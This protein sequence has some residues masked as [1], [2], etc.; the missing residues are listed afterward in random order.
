MRGGT[1]S[2]EV[3]KSACPPGATGDLFREC[4]ANG[5]GGVPFLVDGPQTT[6]A[7][8]AGPIGSVFFGQLPAGRYTIAEMVPSGDYAQYV[9]Y[10]SD[11]AGVEVPFEYRGNGRAAVQ[12]EVADGQHVVC[13]WYN[14]PAPHAIPTAAPDTEIE[15][16]GV[17]LTRTAWG[18]L[19]GSG[20]RSGQVITY[21]DGRYDVAFAQRFVI[22]IE[23]GWEEDGGVTVAAAIDEV[24]GLLPADAELLESFTLPATESGPIALAA[25]RYESAALG[26][27][28]EHLSVPR[29]V[30][31]LVVYQLI[32]ETND[33]EPMVTRVSIAV[34]I[35]ATPGSVGGTQTIA[36]V[37]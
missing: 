14:I 12:L 16:G 6:R 15:S 11:G 20:V 4:H 1:G 9:V 35:S 33:E 3:H 31:I 34:G 37:D 8:T 36:P 24:H 25:E 13:D 28:L 2:I 27:R 29:T 10:C 32:Q 19:H 21:E 26:D 17:G 30:S 5:L 22:F 18:G 23:T 7:A